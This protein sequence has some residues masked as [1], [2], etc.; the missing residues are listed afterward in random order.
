MAEDRRLTRLTKICLALPEATRELHNSHA[1]FAVRGRKFAYFLDDHHGDGIVAVSFRALP[2]EN[3][4]LIA[5]DPTRFFMPSYLGPRGWAAL[6][7]D[8][9]PIDWDEVAELV[10]DSYCLGAPKRLVALVAQPG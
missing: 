10:I 6:H 4:V 8:V 7:L 5:S 3:D 2:G 9:G 1:S